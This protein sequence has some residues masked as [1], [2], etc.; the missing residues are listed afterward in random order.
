[1]S[2]HVRGS[3]PGRNGG[4]GNGEGSGSGIVKGGCSGKTRRSG[5][6]LVMGGVVDV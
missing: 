4:G 6:V 3:G 5:M 2:G 1:M